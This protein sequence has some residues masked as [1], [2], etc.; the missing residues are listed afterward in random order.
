M[1]KISFI[2]MILIAA[3]LL[4]SCVSLKPTDEE[5]EVVGKVGDYDVCYDELRYFVMNYKTQVLDKKYG[6]I[7]GDEEKIAAYNAELL[8]Y[9]SSAI[10]RN[11]AVMVLCDG[12]SVDYD[13]EAILDAVDDYVDSTIEEA[14][15]KREYKKNLEKNYMTDRFYRLYFQMNYYALNELKYVFADDFGFIPGTD[16]ELEA[17]MDSDDFICVR[18]ICVYKDSTAPEA[19]KAKIEMIYDELEGGAVFEEMIGAYS[20][21]YQDT[22]KGFYFTYGEMEK[23]YE[24]AAFALEVGEYSEII[25]NDYGYYI[26]MRCEK[27]DE[28][29]DSQ[30]STFKSQ[31]QYALTYN[32]VSEQ[33]EKLVFE[34]NEYGKSID[35]YG[36]K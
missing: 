2:V 36:M 34:L 35:L 24:D 16:D 29:M 25:E 1:K 5:L 28:Y 19:V 31:I 17:Y 13:A 10:T 3:L 26:I 32:K 12:F 11:Y 33:Q 20:E 9:V 8:E 22:G 14:G 23:E 30:F 27:D 7:S 15:S 4:P 6:D 21:D 18:H